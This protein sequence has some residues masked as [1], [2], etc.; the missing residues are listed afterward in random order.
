MGKVV[1]KSN[2][3]MDI[4]GPKLIPKNCLNTAPVK[5]N[6]AKYQ[7]SKKLFNLILQLEVPILKNQ[8]VMKIN[9]LSIRF[10]IN[11]SKMNM[12]GLC[13]HYRLIY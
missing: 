6:R 13:P 3:A 8:L 7:N 5:P 12:R 2:A 9:N 1:H 11:K 4:I 10:V